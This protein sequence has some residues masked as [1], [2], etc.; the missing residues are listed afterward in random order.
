MFPGRNTATKSKT[1]PR[2]TQ[3]DIVD[4][5]LIPQTQPEVTKLAEHNPDSGSPTDQTPVDTLPAEGS[6]ERFD[7]EV[8]IYYQTAVDPS[9]GS[10]FLDFGNETW[11]TWRSSDQTTTPEL[12][13][14]M[15]PS[16]SSSSVSEGGAL[17]WELEP[18]SLHQIDMKKFE[19]V[20]DFG[21]GE[22][23]SPWPW[24]N[25]TYR[26]P[27]P[28]RFLEPDECL[29]EA[30]FAAMNKKFEE[31]LTE[32]MAEEAIQ[33]GKKAAKWRELIEE[34]TGG[35]RVEVGSSRPPIIAFNNRA[36][37]GRTIYN[38]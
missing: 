2:N 3:T 27:T 30:K 4:E 10:Q 31:R 17:G 15:V 22:T 32:V 33:G 28:P 9:L 24:G 13:S 12:D 7:E 20:P 37:R 8:M 1:V 26:P 14:L 38:P 29:V 6:Q 36:I 25:Y 11:S 34:E 23:V 16:S 19:T 18:S 5:G 35:W 21:G